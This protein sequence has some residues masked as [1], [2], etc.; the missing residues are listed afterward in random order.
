MN[1]LLLSALWDAAFDRGLISF[2]EDGNVL[3]SESISAEAR[4][5]LTASKPLPILASHGPF[6]AW[7]RKMYGFE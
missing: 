1:G 3:H 6:L 4:A 7:H 5:F 2:S